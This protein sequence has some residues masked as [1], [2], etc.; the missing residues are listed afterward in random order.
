[1]IPAQNFHPLKIDCR[2]RP[3]VTSLPYK[4]AASARVMASWQFAGDAN[5]R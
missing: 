2:R 3:F 4:Q 1:M 5:S